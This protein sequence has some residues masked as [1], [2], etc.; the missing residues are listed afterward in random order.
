MIK[1]KEVLIYLTGKRRHAILSKVKL[2][3]NNK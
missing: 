1:A 3:F 2:I